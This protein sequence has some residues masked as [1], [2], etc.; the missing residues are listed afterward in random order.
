VQER[1]QYL[2]IKPGRQRWAMT[3][4]RLRRKN[5]MQSAMPEGLTGNLTP[6]QLADLIAFLKSLK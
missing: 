6:D 5:P 2:Q 3:V 4:K 1:A